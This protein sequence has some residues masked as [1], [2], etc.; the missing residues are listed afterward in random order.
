MVKGLRWV[1]VFVLVIGIASLVNAQHGDP[2]PDGMMHDGQTIIRFAARV[3][4]DDAACGM[5]Y[6]GVGAASSEMTLN[7]MR[8]YVSN[9]RLLA[10]DGSEAPLMLEQDG[11]WQHE[12]VALLD[13]EDGTAGC[14][15]FGN[16]ALNDK[17][18]GMAPE[19]EYTGLA[20]TMGVPFE[21]NHL[22]TTM[23]PSP[24]N[25][26]AMWWNWQFGYKFARV[27]MMAN[28]AVW[29]LH[30]GSTGCVAPNGNTP[31]EAPC[32]NTNA[33]EVRLEAFNP[34]T[35]FV[36]ADLATLLAGVDISSS[37]PEPPGCMSGPDDP[38]CGSVFTG[39]GLDLASGAPLADAAQ[40][41]FR[42]Q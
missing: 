24:L 28:D 11:L 20:F 7:D 22:D 17:V 25:L 34:Q 26:P 35:D 30:L 4:D 41:M 38:D 19:G 13:F 8:F 12:G 33:V 29:L 42:A 31:P 3:G 1:I 6:S 39:L 15:E 18:V 16:S 5:T 10:A 40:Q 14:A 37:T 2:P 32:A 9:I 21:L 27:E 36:V 23:A